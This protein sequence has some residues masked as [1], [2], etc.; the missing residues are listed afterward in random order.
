V[1]TVSSIGYH[2]SE[3]LLTPLQ[4]GI[5]NSRLR[6]YLLARISVPFPYLPQSSL[7]TSP[8]RYIPGRG[9]PWLDP[10]YTESTSITGNDV[11]EQAQTPVDEIHLYLD[12]QNGIDNATYDYTVPDRVLLKWGCLFDIVLPHSRRTCCFT[13]GSL[14]PPYLSKQ[15]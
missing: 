12:K 6:Y 5:P 11:I 8:L 9:E 7:A 2:V 1:K 4:F 13:R 14:I 15:T 10:R 3:H